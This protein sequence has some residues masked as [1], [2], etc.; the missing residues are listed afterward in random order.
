MKRNSL[1]LLTAL[2]LLFTG[3][4]ASYTLPGSGTSS[5]PYEI[6]NLTDLNQTRED[7]DAHYELTSDINASE[8]K[9][10]NDGKG[11]R[12]IGNS[13][14]GFRFEGVFAGN[15]HK[16]KGLNITR[17][18]R[19]QTGIFGANFGFITNVS[20][21]LSEISGDDSVGILVGQNNGNITDSLVM[22]RVSGDRLVGG[23]VGTNRGA[24]NRSYSEGEVKGAVVVVKGAT[25]RIYTSNEVYENETG[26]PTMT[27]GGTGDVLTGVIASL[28]SRGLNLEDSAKLGTWINGKAG[29]RAA[30]KYGNGALATDMVEKI[31]EVMDES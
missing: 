15:N 23:L 11:W 19:S 4:T 6:S 30:E 28:I 31:P 3:L 21:V 13:T 5:D 1:I 14:S 7:L 26:H 8:T 16:I 2:L 27:V 18:S 29:E 24:I 10:W 9:N 17:G 12:P 25:D 22:G 20:V